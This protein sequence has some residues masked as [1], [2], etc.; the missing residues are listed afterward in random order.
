MKNHKVGDTV[1]LESSSYWG[2]CDQCRNGRVDLCDKALNFWRSESIGFS[3][4]IPVSEECLL[5]FGNLRFEVACL[6][7]PYSG[8]L[9]MTYTA[10]FALGDDALVF[11]LGPIGLMPIP[12]ARLK[13]AL[14]IYA[15]N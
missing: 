3:E 10:Y 12:L 9:D 4:H 1:G 13:G 11:G 6:A 7:E 8:A 2:M 14:Q 15:V 5:H